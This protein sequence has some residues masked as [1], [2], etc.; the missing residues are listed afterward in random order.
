M[1]KKQ[2]SKNVSKEDILAKMMEWHTVLRERL[3]RTGKQG[4]CDDKWG[5]FPLECRFNVD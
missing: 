2:R 4:D 3:I 1:R 5:R